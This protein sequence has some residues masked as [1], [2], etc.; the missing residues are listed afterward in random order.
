MDS[1]KINIKTEDLVKLFKW[2]DYV[3]FVLM[4]ASSAFIGVWF[5]FIKKK[6]RGES[7]TAE[8]LTASGTMGWFPMSMSLIAR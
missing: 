7:E 3:V 4:L 1:D 6:K 5:G 8:F 2:P